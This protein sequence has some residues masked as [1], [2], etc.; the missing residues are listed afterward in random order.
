ML[1][2]A[3]VIRAT[4]VETLKQQ[5]SLHIEFFSVFYKKVSIASLRSL[6]NQL[7]E[8]EGRSNLMQPHTKKYETLIGH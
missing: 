7:A 5:N 3:N 8:R 1:T 6:L 2:D 4:L